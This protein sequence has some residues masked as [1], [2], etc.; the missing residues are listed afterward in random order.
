MLFLAFVLLSVHITT[1]AQS[2]STELLC[3]ATFP[4]RPQICPDIYLPVCAS[5]PRTCFTLPCP[6]VLEFP[7]DCV[8]CSDPI[9]T[10]YRPGPCEEVVFYIGEEEVIFE[11]FL[12]GE[13][14]YLLGGEEEQGFDNTYVTV[15]CPQ[16]R[17]ALCA[18]IFDPVCVTECVSG[19]CL[20]TSPSACNAC[21]DVNVLGYTPQSCEAKRVQ[22]PVLDLTA[23]DVLCND[24]WD[25]VCA[26]SLDSVDGSGS[27]ASNAC[28]ACNM[29]GADYYIKG[30]CPATPTV[31]LENVESP[32][33]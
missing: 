24:L 2:T 22:C 14:E 13:E 4:E 25:P 8:A 33:L 23:T 19:P 30:E 32:V 15:G 20:Y 5:Y 9:V 11:E 10:S 26:Y 6:Q 28:H 12:L 17:P 27:T 3:S 21:A 7:S 31:A 1:F 18:E 16:M 29:S